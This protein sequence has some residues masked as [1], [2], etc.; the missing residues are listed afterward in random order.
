MRVTAGLRVLSASEHF[1]REGN[2]YYAGGPS[3]AAI[4]TSAHAVTPR[5]SASWDLDRSTTVYLNIAKGLRL[6]GANRP[7][8]SPTANPLVGDDLKSLGLGGTPPATFD[9]DTLWSYEIGTKSRFFDNRV[10]LNLAAFHIDWKNIQQD[11]ILP[12]SGYDFETNAG[13][14]KVNGFELEGRWLA[15]D[16][17]TLSAG[18]SYTRAVFSE[19]VPALGHDSNGAL[20]VHAGD[21]IQGVPKYSARL[22]FDYRFAQSAIGSVFVRGSG[23]WTGSSHGIL[24]PGSTDYIRP[25]YFTADASAGT[26]LDKWALT[27]FVKNLTNNHTI[28]QQP[29]IQSLNE[30][31]YLRPRTIGMSASYDF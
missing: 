25:A 22:A 14:A 19:D 9:P 18:A 21:P 1:T 29:D 24:V 10:S 4:D 17:L 16:G 8:P 13:N 20:N 23:Q 31:Y 12:A 30:A 28:I 5:Y 2:F 27:V 3:T 6:G 26:T 7:I 11:V 15:T